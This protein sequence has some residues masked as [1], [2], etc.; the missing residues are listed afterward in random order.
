M[1]HVC[2]FWCMLAYFTVFCCILQYFGVKS[3]ICVSCSCVYQGHDVQ[4]KSREANSTPGSLY[5]TRRCLSL[6]QR[7]CWET[8]SSPSQYASSTSISIRGAS[9]GYTLSPAS[10]GPACTGKGKRD[11]TIGSVGGGAG[12]GGRLSHSS[13]GYGPGGGGGGTCREADSTP[14]ATR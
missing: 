8:S 7:N 4:D 1:V 5:F 13:V 9:R 2:A 11:T 6:L 12:G 14:A 3:C 10:G